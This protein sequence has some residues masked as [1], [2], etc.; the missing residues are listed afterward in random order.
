MC[1]I[2]EGPNLKFMR[3]YTYGDIESFLSLYHAKL[4]IFSFYTSKVSNG[5]GISLLTT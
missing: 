3:T 4:Y 1:Y 2:L 5:C